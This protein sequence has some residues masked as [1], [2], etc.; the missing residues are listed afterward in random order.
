M[1]NITQEFGW[2]FINFENPKKGD[3]VIALSPEEAKELYER[4][5]QIFEP[6]GKEA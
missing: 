2:Y 4:L 6:E 5:K 3:N 1:I